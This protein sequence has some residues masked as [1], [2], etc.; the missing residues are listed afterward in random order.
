MEHWS[1]LLQRQLEKEGTVMKALVAAL[2]LGLAVPAHAFY[3][4]QTD[5]STWNEDRVSVGLCRQRMK[6]KN[7]N[8]SDHQQNKGSQVNTNGTPKLRIW[9]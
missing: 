8:A 5:C 9:D 2:I 1:T 4:N 3:D 6:L 7:G